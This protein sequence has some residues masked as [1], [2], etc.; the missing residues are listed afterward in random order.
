MDKHAN[1]VPVHQSPRAVPCGNL[2]LQPGA[3]HR[4]GSGRTGDQTGGGRARH[5][6]LAAQRDRGLSGFD[7][8]REAC[9][10]RFRPIMMTTMAAL[11]GGVPLMLGSG[12]GAELRQPLGYSMV[13]GLI[14]SQALTLYTTPVV[15]LYLE[16][17]NSWL[18]N[19]SRKRTPDAD[20]TVVPLPEQR[21]V[22]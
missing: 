3:E 22:S 19:R 10:L 14:L 20:D 11:L 21:L 9:L 5:A 12:T 1:H 15:F 17:I 8:I 7:A 13:G 18:S 16:R 6:A 4:P 2:E